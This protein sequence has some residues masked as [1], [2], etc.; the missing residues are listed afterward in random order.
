M[1]KLLI[2]AALVLAALLMKAQAPADSVSVMFQRFKDT[3]AAMAQLNND[4]KAHAVMVCGGGA[5]MTAGLLYAASCRSERFG[6]ESFSASKLRTGLCIASV[7]AAVI[8]L[9]VIPI[10]RHGVTLDE[11]GLVVTPSK[12]AKKRK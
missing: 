11:R 2:L 12:L 10:A 3:N 7:G 9:S 5:V 8:V 1:K 6:V 4:M